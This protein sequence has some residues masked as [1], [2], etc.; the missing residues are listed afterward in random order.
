MKKKVAF[1]SKKDIPKIDFRE[2]TYYNKKRKSTLLIV[3]KGILMKKITLLLV[4]LSMFLISCQSGADKA[5][6]YDD[7]SLIA[8]TEDSYYYSV[9]EDS[10]ETIANQMVLDFRS[11]S[12]R[13]TLFSLTVT[14]ESSI[15]LSYQSNVEVGNLKLVIVDE[16]SQVQTLFSGQNDS[17]TSLTLSEGTYMIKLVGSK[18]FGDIDLL[19][20]YPTGVTITKP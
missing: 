15:T 17:S 16:A 19:I 12:G 5:A 18:A 6:I 3:K 20:T 1:L 9:Y 2:L 10:S 13:D 7:D 14:A 4:L 11:F 8:L